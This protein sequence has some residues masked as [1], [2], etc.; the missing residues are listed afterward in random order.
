MCAQLTAAANVSHLPALALCAE[1]ADDVAQIYIA[2][3]IS[4][5]LFY[6]KGVKGFSKICWG[7]LL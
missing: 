3:A 7:W 5:C 1:S 2:S 4:R 6:S